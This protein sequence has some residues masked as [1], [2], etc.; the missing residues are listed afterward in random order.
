M[1]T[2]TDPP[3]V[4][5]LAD[6]QQEAASADVYQNGDMEIPTRKL[7][8]HVLQ[9]KCTKDQLVVDAGAN[10]GYF[11]TYSAVLGCSVKSFEPQPR[12]LP[13]IQSSWKI[14]GVDDRTTLYNNILSENFNE[15]LGIVYVESMCWGCSRVVPVGGAGSHEKQFVITSTRI[16]KHVDEDVLLMK[17]DV[18]GFEVKAIQSASKIFRKHK[19]KNMIIEWS[20]KRWP[21]PIADGDRLLEKLY[22]TGFT[23]RHYDLRMTLP[24]PDI[25]NPEESFPI[26][27]RAW[28]V[29]REN[30]A[31]MNEFL[32]TKDA[33]GEANL[34]LRLE[35]EPS[36]PLNEI[37]KD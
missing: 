15:K 10:L 24:V 12:L 26:I 34:W 14:N 19:V 2:T 25:A 31:K 3:F 20:A 30:L 8:Q 35:R 5:T 7:F 27:G 36:K 33:Y 11:S 28:E 32:H 37:W 6:P 23:I 4:A 17:V 18:E 1:A 22:D 21:H 9:H 13:I 29:P 16:D